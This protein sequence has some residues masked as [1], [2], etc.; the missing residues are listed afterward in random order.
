M[1]LRFLSAFGLGKSEPEEPPLPP[2][3]QL[4]RDLP[5]TGEVAQVVE[6]YC[7]DLAV[8]RKKRR[9]E[10]ASDFKLQ[11]HYGGRVVAIMWTTRGP[12][13]VAVGDQW[14]EEPIAGLRSRLTPQ[15]NLYTHFEY[16]P[17]WGD[18]T[19]RIGVIESR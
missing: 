15:E 19:T 12:A 14:E 8:R 13:V 1:L 7:R 9:E 3:A 18:E 4:I 16:I 5:L 6:A 11:Y 2:G 17:P 10:V